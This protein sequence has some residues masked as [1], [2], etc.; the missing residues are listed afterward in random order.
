VRKT[1]LEA[2]EHQD[3]PFEKLVEELEA[4]RDL[5]RAP[6][7]QVK[8]VLQNAGQS[9]GK[10]S[11]LELEGFEGEHRVA[12]FDL[13]MI[14][15]EGAEGLSGSLEYATDLFER[16]SV[17][18][19]VEYL[20]RVLAMVTQRPEQRVADICMLS[21]AERM[22]LLQWR[23]EEGRY[24]QQCVH[25]LFTQQAIATPDAVA[26]A[27][28]ERQVSYGE[29]E[30]KAN[31]LG[32]YLRRLGVGDEV[33]VG[34]CMERSPEMVLGIL[35]IL[36]AGGT[37]VPLD[38]SY[39]VERLGYILEDAL[40]PILLTQQ[41]L[42]ERFPANWAQIVCLEREWQEINKQSES[43][44]EKRKEI[45]SKTDN[46][47][48]VMYTSG[49][50]GEPKGVA[51]QQGSIVRLVKHTNYIELGPEEV[52][53]QYA[54][55]SFDASTFEIWGS[56][57]NGGR[58][59]IFPAHQGSMD[60]LG[61]EIEQEGIT[62]TWLTAGLFHQ[63]VAEGLKGFA[64]VK[65]IVAGGE[66]LSV[67]D[68]RSVVEHLPAARLINGYGPTE[69]T[70]FTACH[71][72][73]EV[74]GN[75][76]SVPIGKA[77]RNTQVYVLDEYGSLAPTGASGEL[78]VGGAGLARG[79]VGYVEL[80]AEKFV[81]DEFSS[82]PGT[83]L[84]R[85]GDRVRWNQQGELE[86]LGRLDQ[87]IKLRG[88]R[89]EPGEIEAVLE[90]HSAVEQAVVAVREDMPGDRRLVAYVVVRQSEREKQIGHVL[91]EYAGAK[92]PNYMVPAVVMELPEIPLTPNGK[93]DRKAL[94]KP[95]WESSAEDYIAPRTAVEE[96]LCKIWMQVLVLERVGINDNFFALG[97]HSLLATQV[98]S[99]IR[100]FFGIDLPLRVLFS[101]ATL[102]Q[103][104][105]S[106]E[107]ALLSKI[108]QVPEEEAIE[109]VRHANSSE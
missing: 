4:E 18:R 23:G 68:V 31:Q 81:P 76:K 7:F 1:V 27:Q 96:I 61:S 50:S 16:A 36:K 78:Y 55:A 60:E 14:L 99:R 42:Q 49:S 84:Y 15:Q 38:P 22:R 88:Y 77:I 75:M 30:R 5:G 85:T 56:L 34:L 25:E 98:A 89:I 57:L 64:G 105:E 33:C 74:K 21:P 71:W 51:V 69:N 79:Y 82:V 109:M 48:Y 45:S 10:L 41:G 91:W 46:L 106:V 93:I 2:Y 29:L 92:L 94:P 32:H 58:L 20:S 80:T 102:E 101:A 83:R 72:V 52:M 67:E 11:G 37:Y 65:Q 44:V 24:P 40:V 9:Q 70:T 90:G 103:L 100:S 39:P 63:V 95:Y 97:G 28:Q 47:A 17:E 108:E 54:P 26:L 104:A 53:L 43:S 6:L 66:A 59:Q 3:V 19:L 62:I 86:F 73:R 12:K 8:L 35:G 87:Q 107:D 13:T